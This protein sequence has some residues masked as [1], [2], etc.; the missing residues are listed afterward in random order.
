MVT[1]EPLTDL[2]RDR[3]ADAVRLAET[4]T[5]AEIV[6]AIETDSCEEFDAT[7]ALVAAGLIAIASAAPLDFLGLTETM[8]VAVQ[9]ALFAMLATVAASSRARSVLGLTRLPGSAARRAAQKAFD[10]LGLAR[11]RERTGVLIHVALAERHVE[12]IADEG[13]HA[14]VAPETW[15]ELVEAIVGAAKAGHLADGVVR[16]VQRCGEAL[17]DVLPPT[18][19]V[20]DELP[21][22]PVTR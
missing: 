16:A 1:R 13:V 15:D 4:R 12:V 19:G 21:N 7:V 3:I 9:F 20:G 11:T 14:A 17:A 18:R 22:A 2:E 8:V 6:V 10:E 5:A